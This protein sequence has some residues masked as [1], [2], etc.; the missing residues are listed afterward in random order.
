MF[1]ISVLN[2]MLYI[3]INPMP[4][5]SSYMM[6]HRNISNLNVEAN[7]EADYCNQC[8]SWEMRLH[9]S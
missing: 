4:A 2:Y 9:G 5:I 8:Q 3:N 7:H 1:D 6:F